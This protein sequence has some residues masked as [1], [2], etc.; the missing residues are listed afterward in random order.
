M[1]SALRNL[2]TRLRHLGQSAGTLAELIDDHAEDLELTTAEVQRI[3][4][5]VIH[6]DRRLNAIAD[7]FG[8]GH[9]PQR[10]ESPRD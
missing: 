3:C 6:L 1:S 7:Q 10:E 5:Q 9:D 4:V 8:E 2:A